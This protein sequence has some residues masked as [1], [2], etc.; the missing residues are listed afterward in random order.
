MSRVEMV[1]DPITRIA[2]HLGVRVIVDVNA[3]RPDPTTVRAFVTM[4]RGFEVFCAGRPPEDLPH[5]T[6][7]LCGVCGASH[8]NADVIAVDMAYGVTPEPMGVVL[9]NLAFA[10]T[11]HIYDHPTVLTLL[12]GVDYSE[13]IVS[14]LTPKVYEEA[15]RTYAEHRDIHGFTTIADIMKALNPI[16][17]KMWQ[18]A[19]HFQRY[20]REAGVLIYG[21]HSHPP[22]IIPGG[23]GTDLTDAESLILGYTY[24]LVRLTAW[25]KYFYLVWEDLLRFYEHMGYADNGLTYYPLRAMSVG[26]FDDPEG[27]SA[28]G[29]HVDWEDVYK[30]IDEPMKKRVTKPGLII[31]GELV[32]DRYTDINVSTMEHVER[33]FYEDW[34]DKVKKLEWYTE[35]DPLGNKL[36]WGHYDPAYHPWNKVTIPK[37]GVLD[38]ADKYTWDAHVRIAW[39]NGKIVPVEVGPYANLLATSMQPS[40][41][42]PGNGV[43]KVT[44]PRACTNELP[45]AVCDEMTFEWKIP[46]KSTTIYRLWARAFKVL[47]AIHASWVNVLKALELLRAGKVKASRPWRAPARITRGVGFTEA[48]RG[49]VRHWIVQSGGKTLNIQIHAPT[50]VNVSPQDKWGF[51]SFEQSVANSWVTEEVD[52][53]EWQGLDF[54]RAIR[55]FDPCLPC[56][57][58]VQ[59]IDK[60]NIVKKVEKILRQVECPI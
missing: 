41:F 24:R 40:D 42:G 54:V 60:N 58:H 11:D 46:L 15:K 50:T 5:I 45:P 14:K 31:D 57:V 59:F 27:Y 7:R 48:P 23:M 10:M 25:A 19:V 36:L 52:P 28:I 20:A 34:A 29:G 6:S 53:K 17:G 2:G 3:R 51:G 22:T 49:S 43:L 16:E 30:G 33:S 55:S 32:T 4:F 35:S 37:P 56:A 39:K 1:I 38:W 8:A 13:A 18:L 44:L 47:V 9:R 21:R 12:Q 26:L